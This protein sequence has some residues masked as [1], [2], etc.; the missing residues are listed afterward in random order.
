MATT[1]LFTTD[2]GLSALA[3]FDTITADFAASIGSQI[4]PNAADL[5]TEVL[6]GSGTVAILDVISAV[7]AGPASAADGATVGGGPGDGGQ[8]GLGLGGAPDAPDADTGGLGTAAV[9]MVYGADVQVVLQGAGDLLPVL[10]F[11]FD[12][13]PGQMGSQVQV[14]LAD[15][16]ATIDEDDLIRVRIGVRDGS[17]TEWCKLVGGA[18]ITQLSK[19]TG[20]LNDTVS[21][22]A[23]NPMA[24]KWARSP[25]VPL[26][27]YDPEQITLIS[28]SETVPR[29]IVDVDR[30]VIT[31]EFQAVEG[32][33]LHQ[34]LQF[35]YV[36]KCG[37]ADIITNIPNYT[38]KRVDFTLE[39]TWHSVAA[40]E[41]GAF[42]P[43][44]GS[45][46]ED[47]L[48]ILDPQG[49]L[50]EDTPATLKKLKPRAYSNMQESK[51]TGGMVNAVLLN[52]RDNTL[53][54]GTFSGG[55]SD[56]TEQEIQEVG[57]FGQ[58]GWQRTLI[59]RFVKDFHD[60]PNNPAEVTRS[61]VWK[62]DT[63]TSAF[64]DSLIREIAIESQVD[65][66]TQDWR[67]KVGYI[68]TLSIYTALPGVSAAMTETQTETNR[69]VW[70]V[71]QS[72]PSETYKVWETTSVSGIGLSTDNGDDP[73]TRISLFDANRSNQ[74]TD[75]QTVLLATP[76]TTTSAKFRT[77][78][79]RDQIEEQYQTI[80]HLSG[81]PAQIRT[82]HHTGTTAVRT[83]AQEVTARMLITNGDIPEE[84][85]RP[86]LQF[87]AGNIPFEIAKPLAE[88]LL[89]RR[90]A[91]P[92]TITFDL[93]G[94]DLSL[95]RGS[96][97]RVFTR[98]GTIYKTFVTGYS[99][100]GE[101][102]PKGSVVLSMSGT[103]IVI[104]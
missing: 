21:F 39:A 9:G 96:L 22:T 73:P 40:A 33:D 27:L 97:R 30:N 32:F 101:P 35:V 51:Q 65:E 7:A 34:L 85:A 100:T 5:A 89:A 81:K 69:V 1:H 10:S 103:G 58:T 98:D 15:P 86:P 77:I 104:E 28:V 67:L 25:R 93:A 82:F 76:I 38:L 13:P 26:V 68:K 4:V 59:N 36:D 57:T 29:D 49:V 91:K 54:A 64:V 46:D 44:Y 45:D 70:A 20:Y 87:N 88:R 42:E 52:F 17:S 19:T 12:A 24:D 3:A 43:V 8:G 18:R 60:N 83:G 2:L 41:T 79:D 6:A 56:R 53:T 16:L 74:I 23:F 50:P 95:R 80:D 55:E 94:M 72:D 78:G 48:F 90:G 66:Y 84:E 47:R 31:P 102:G 37:F 71:S 62:S 99:V 14:T 92:R 75:D 11:K 61:I 63:R